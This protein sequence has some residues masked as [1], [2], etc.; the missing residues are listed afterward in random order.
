MEDFRFVPPVLKL[1]FL[2]LPSVKQHFKKLLTPAGK[3][4]LTRIASASGACFQLFMLTVWK[5]DLIFKFTPHNI[6]QRF[7]IDSFSEL[8]ANQ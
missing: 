7:I 6:D 4:Q 1:F 3:H 5:L 2:K 8:E